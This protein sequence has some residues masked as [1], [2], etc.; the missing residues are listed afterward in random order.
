MDYGKIYYRNE[1]K[2]TNEIKIPNGISYA[3]KPKMFGKKTHEVKIVFKDN[4]SKGKGEKHG[5]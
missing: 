3:E 5:K 4:K 2:N 1:I